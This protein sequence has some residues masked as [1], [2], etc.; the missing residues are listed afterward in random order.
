MESIGLERLGTLIRGACEIDQ[1]GENLSPLRLPVWT[2]SQQADR[3]I[4]LW[5]AQTVGVRIV[6]RTAASRIVVRATVTRMVPAGADLPAFESCF[7]ATSG[8]AELARSYVVDGPLILTGADRTWVDVPGDAAEFVLDVGGSAVAREV[9][10]WLPHNAQVVIHAVRAD[11]PL[12]R[13]DSSTPAWVHHGSSVSHCLEATSPL[14][15]WPQTAARA[16][17]LELTNLAIAGNAQLDPFVARTIAQQPA[18]VISLKLGVNVV[19]VDSMRRR[20]FIPALHGFLDLVREGHPDTPVVVITALACPELEHTPGPSRKLADG[21][22][23]GTPRP[24]ADGDGTLTLSRTRELV[25]S[26]VG[27]RDDDLLFLDDGLELFGHGDA[28]YLWDGLHP[29]QAGYDVI[30][31]RFLSRARDGGTGIGRAFAGVLTNT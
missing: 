7:V 3:W 28:H 12:E 26:V 30:S 19:N 23:Y 22:Y 2:R 29:D 13:L 15:P 4:E 5:S 8:S 20:T 17:G 27:A 16:L 6:A 21:R 18:D 31:E 9:T 25:S 1:R 24:M 11:A 10:V 14:G